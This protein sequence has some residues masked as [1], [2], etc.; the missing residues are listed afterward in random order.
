MLPENHSL[1][2]VEEKWDFNTDFQKYKHKVIAEALKV[3]VQNKGP[4]A[5]STNY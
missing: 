5:T 4:R 2:A 1:K 3:W